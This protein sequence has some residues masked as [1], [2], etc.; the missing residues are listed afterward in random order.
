MRS[1]FPWFAYG[2]GWAILVAGVLLAYWLQ[3]L[4]VLL[5]IAFGVLLSLVPLTITLSSIIRYE[6][7]EWRRRHRTCTTVTV[8]G[9][10]MGTHKRHV[11]RQLRVTHGVR[12][13]PITRRKPSHA[14]AHVQPVPVPVRVTISHTTRTPLHALLEL[15]QQDGCVC[16][17]SQTHIGKLRGDD[18]G[19]AA[20]KLAH[21]LNIPITVTHH[22]RNTVICAVRAADNRSANFSG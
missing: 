4:L 18:V 19:R 14:R 20:L 3:S 9:T 22:A 5:C 13:E 15:V 21:R 11:P 12:V 7:A 17:S 6:L 2:L 8:G 1:E 16:I 10:P